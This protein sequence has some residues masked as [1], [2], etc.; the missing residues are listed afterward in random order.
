M[1]QTHG[2]TGLEALLLEA[3]TVVVDSAGGEVRLPRSLMDAARMGLLKSPRL[4][5]DPDS[6]TYIFSSHPVPR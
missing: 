1:A 2:L 4:R 3:L 5:F 6:E